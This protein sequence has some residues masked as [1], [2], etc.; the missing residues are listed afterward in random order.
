MSQIT[1]CDRCGIKSERSLDMS[2]LTFQKGKNLLTYEVY[3][4]DLC[5]KC[6]DE[7]ASIVKEWVEKEH[8]KKN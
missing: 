3:R 4:Y 2:H 6:T 8:D 7:L 5:G 1:E